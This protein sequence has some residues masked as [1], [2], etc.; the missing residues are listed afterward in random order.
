VVTDMIKKGVDV[1]VLC[2]GKCASHWT[3]LM[4]AALYG[5]VDVT[6][7]LIDNDTDVNAVRE[8]GLTPLHIAT[9]N[10]ESTLKPKT[11]IPRCTLRQVWTTFKL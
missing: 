5:K 6:K 11:E 9:I 1:N 10:L 7:A 2:H 4:I 3:P 8:H